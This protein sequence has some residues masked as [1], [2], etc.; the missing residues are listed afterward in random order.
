LSTVKRE[1]VTTS[2]VPTNRTAYLLSKCYSLV[3]KMSTVP[4]DVFHA[5]DV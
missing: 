1:T 4:S 3:K 5:S 2:N